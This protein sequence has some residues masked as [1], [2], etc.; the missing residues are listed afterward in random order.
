[1]C[2]CCGLKNIFNLTI[3]H[4]ISKSMKRKFKK[5]KNFDIEKPSNLQLLC[6]AC[7]LSKNGHKKHCTLPHDNPEIKKMITKARRRKSKK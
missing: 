7:N 4:I 6:F 1:M 5:Y 2:A 3:D